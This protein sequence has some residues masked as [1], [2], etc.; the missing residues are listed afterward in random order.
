MKKVKPFIRAI[1]KFLI[2]VVIVAI[3]RIG[4]AMYIDQMPKYFEGQ[5]NLGYLL[6]PEKPLVGFFGLD[7]FLPFGL[8]LGIAL[9]IAA[10]YGYLPFYFPCL[11]VNLP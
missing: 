11:G 4:L 3:F 8:V 7:R 1:R 10:F 5:N 9:V 2:R 6:F